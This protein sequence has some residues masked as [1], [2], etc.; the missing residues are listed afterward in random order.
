MHTQNH[1]HTQR[2][3][4]CHFLCLFLLFAMIQCKKCN[5]SEL[6][7]HKKRSKFSVNELDVIK[8]KTEKSFIFKIIS[9]ATSSSSPFFF[10]FYCF[11]FKGL[12]WINWSSTLLRLSIQWSG[13]RLAWL[14]LFWCWDGSCTAAALKGWHKDKPLFHLTQQ[15]LF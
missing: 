1:T 4:L 12:F 2:G 14:V 8:T 13:M 5:S 10:F 15:L 6:F 3:Y 9:W 7:S 11:I